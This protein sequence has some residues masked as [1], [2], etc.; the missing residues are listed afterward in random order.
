MTNEQRERLMDLKREINSPKDR[1][2][3]LM[4]RIE[5]V[6]PSQAAKLGKIIASLETFQNR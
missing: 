5:E 2:M 4:R 3:S 6:S 1:L